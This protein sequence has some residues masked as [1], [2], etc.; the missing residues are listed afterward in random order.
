[1]DWGSIFNID[2]NFVFNFAVG[3]ATIVGLPITI[4]LQYRPKSF[5]YTVT[6]TPI[7]SIH[8]KIDDVAVTYKGKRVENL[9]VVLVT[10]WNSGSVPI[11]KTDFEPPV[12]FCNERTA[13]G[14]SL[15][16]AEI[17]NAPEA[18]NAEVYSLKTGH[19]TYRTAL[20]NMMF[21]PGDFV[22]VRIIIADYGGENLDINV[23]GR[24]EGVKAFK[25]EPSFNNLP[26]IIRLIFVPKH[27][28]SSAKK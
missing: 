22:T 10:V 21:N 3:V 7:V 12:T 24:I 5:S 16:V 27:P 8:Q 4:A 18:S 14:N 19:H 28:Q 17:I 6:D 20:K 26:P 9:R 23:T 11:K 13:R 15:V 1:M 25:K 2:W